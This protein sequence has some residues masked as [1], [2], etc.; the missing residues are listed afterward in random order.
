MIG[1]PESQLVKTS[2]LC[3][4]GPETKGLLEEEIIWAYCFKDLSHDLTPSK[5]HHGGSSIWKK[6]L[7]E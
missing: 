6:L 7:T 2:C 5:A 1:G 3:G 4:K